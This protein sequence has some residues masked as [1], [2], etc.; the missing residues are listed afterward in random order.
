MRQQILK[1]KKKEQN[2]LANSQ[3]LCG[4]PCIRDIMLKECKSVKEFKLSFL[5]K[6]QKKVLPM[7]HSY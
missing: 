5:R 1:R 7:G 6:G 2:I 3:C 4:H